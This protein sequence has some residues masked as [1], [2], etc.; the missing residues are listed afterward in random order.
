MPPDAT[1]LLAAALKSATLQGSFL[2]QT[3]G[4]KL[5]LDKFQSQA[6]ARWLANAGVLVLG[7]DSS[8]EFSLEYRKAHSPPPAPVK[9]KKLAAAR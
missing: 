2:P 7:F 3:L 1:A 4:A 9:R 5:G 8:A 6:A